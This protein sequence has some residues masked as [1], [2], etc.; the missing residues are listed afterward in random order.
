MRFV[1]LP[2]P[3]MI[4]ELPPTAVELASSAT[5]APLGC[6]TMNGILHRG[7]LPGFPASFSGALSGWPVGQRNLIMPVLGMSHFAVA[8]RG[9]RG[10][11]PT[12]MLSSPPLR[13]NGEHNLTLT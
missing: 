3:A 10:R 12:S 2:D 6:G 4:A 1:P 11:G 9:R 5:M 7:H 13:F 8:A